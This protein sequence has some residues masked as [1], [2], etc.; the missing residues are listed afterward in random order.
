M[1]DNVV[2][3][4]VVVVVL[5]VVVVGLVVVGVAVVLTENIRMKHIFRYFDVLS[6]DYKTHI[7]DFLYKRWCLNTI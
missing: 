6:Y 2:C 5:G 3:F 1:V 4:L 7:F